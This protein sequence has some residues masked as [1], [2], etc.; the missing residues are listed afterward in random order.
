MPDPDPVGELATLHCGSI[1]EHALDARAQRLRSVDH[2]DRVGAPIEVQA[3]RDQVFQQRLHHRGVLGRSLPQ[4]QHV[5]G[6]VRGHAQ[7]HDQH[8]SG[9]LDPIDQ[10]RHQMEFFQPPLAHLA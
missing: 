10:Q 3:A 1:S 5:L 8:L 2:P 6:A 9:E 7:G 4:P